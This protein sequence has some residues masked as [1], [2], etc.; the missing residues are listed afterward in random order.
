MILLTL[1][2]SKFR[3]KWYNIDYCFL[4]TDPHVYGNTFSRS[5]IKKKNINVFLSI[6]FVSFVLNFIL[7]LFCRCSIN[8]C[9][10]HFWNRSKPNLQVSDIQFYSTSF[11]PNSSLHLLIN[12]I[13]QIIFV[14]S[15]FSVF[16][17]PFFIPFCCC[18]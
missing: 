9:K 12:I 16:I 3:T 6:R 18:C 7:F 17:F 10:N 8:N 14:V 1:L 4:I 2:T 11:T 15:H 13:Q 5:V